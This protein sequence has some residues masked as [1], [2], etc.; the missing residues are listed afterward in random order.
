MSEEKVKGEDLKNVKRWDLLN[1][2]VKT[3]SDRV[4]LEKAIEKLIFDEKMRMDLGRN[5]YIK[6]KSKYEWKMSFDR[7][8]SVL[9]SMKP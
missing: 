5:A 7:Y 3:F 4:A 1:W 2:G 9:Y 6:A 8:R